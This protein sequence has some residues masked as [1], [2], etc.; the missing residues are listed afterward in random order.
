MITCEGVT[1]MQIQIIAENERLIP[2]YQHLGDAGADLVAKEAVK[3]W[4]G[5]IKRIPTGIRLAIP[6]GLVGLIMPRSGLASR[7]LI[8][9]PGTIDSGYRG[10]VKVVM[11]YVSEEG[12]PYTISAGDRIAQLEIIPVVQAEFQCV[13][14]LPPGQRGEKGFGSTGVAQ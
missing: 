13:N 4:P 12:R 14:E 2:Y 8:V 11:Y 10:E 9:I 6:E 7:G 3:I 1:C 5:E